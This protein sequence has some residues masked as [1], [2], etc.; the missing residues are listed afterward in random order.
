MS[1][2]KPLSSL[3]STK[4]TPATSDLAKKISGKS[5]SS[6]KKIQIH[7]GNSKLAKW[8]KICGYG[9]TGGGKTTAITKFLKA[10]LKVLVITTDFGGSGMSTVFNDLED[11][12]NPP[13]GKSRPI[14]TQSQYDTYLAN[15]VHMDLESYEQVIEFLEDPNRLFSEALG[16]DLYTGF[17]PDMLV[18]DGF[19]GFQQIHLS[20]YIGD[21]TPAGKEGKSVSEGRDSGL[22]FETQDWGMIRNGTLRPL[23][24]FLGLHNK[25]TGKAWHKYI[26]MQEG[27]SK[28]N[29][30]TLDFSRGPM[31]QGASRDLIEPAFDI[32][33]RMRHR[34]PE[35]KEPA[36]KRVYIYEC[37]GNDGIV[38]KSRSYGLD[39]IEPGDMSLV[40]AKIKK[41]LDGPNAIDVPVIVGDNGEDHV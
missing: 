11:E 26:T 8:V 12:L 35:G 37:E 14:I 31:L 29:K 27:I 13:D 25:T 17:D 32:I 6:K 1:D 21:M 33:V 23:N 3:T 10:G 38:A 40:W 4:S 24:Q 36:G 18:W 34:A 19:S 9:H 28:Q 22:Q 30:L 20:L 41:R 5:P 7:R 15:L 2:I 39:P 16:E